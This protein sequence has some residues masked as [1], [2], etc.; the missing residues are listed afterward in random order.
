NVA[1]GV[2]ARTRI[3]G[4]SQLDRE[5]GAR[6]VPALAFD[7]ADDHQQHHRADHAVDDRS[8]EA[9][10][11]H[12]TQLRQ[13]PRADERADDADD[14]VPEQA[15]ADPAHDLPGQPAGNCAGHEAPDDAQTLHDALPLHAKGRS[16]SATKPSAE[17]LAG[18]SND[19]SWAASYR[20]ISR[21]MNSRI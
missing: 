8:D 16:R 21:R 18:I 20:L 17:S 4:D 9:G 3:R 14:D 5:D 15:E 6:A 19:V 11:R 12:E 10:K 7:E 13:Q 2:A 1:H